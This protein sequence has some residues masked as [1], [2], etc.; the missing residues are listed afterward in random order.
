M[1]PF[2]TYYRNLNEAG[3]ALPENIVR[4]HN[5]IGTNE[6]LLGSVIELDEKNPKS[7]IITSGEYNQRLL[8][9]YNMSEN[10]KSWRSGRKGGKIKANKVKD[11]K[12]KMCIWT[13]KAP[14]V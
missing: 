13:I 7:I 12:I 10:E 2:N 11:Q 9:A 5:L 8:N 4:E 6:T 3:V 1:D 14:K